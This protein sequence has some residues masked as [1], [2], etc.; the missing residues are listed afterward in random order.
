L[1]TEYSTISEADKSVL[2][3]SARSDGGGT[4]EQS[5]QG[6][7][8]QSHDE[9][10]RIKAELYT[11]R[12]AKYKNASNVNEITGIPKKSTHTEPIG[13]KRWLSVLR[14]RAKPIDATSP[15]QPFD[16]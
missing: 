13:H 4:A 6:A 9:T 16:R 3:V 5:H 7:A 11:T 1:L 14:N 15:F 8:L 2:E 10:G 12:K